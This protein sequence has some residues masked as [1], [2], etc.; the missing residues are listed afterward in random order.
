MEYTK[1]GIRKEDDV[2]LKRMGHITDTEHEEGLTDKAVENRDAIAQIK[3]KMVLGQLTRE[4]AKREAKPIIDEM[5][6]RIIEIGKEY[7]VKPKLLS[8]ISLMR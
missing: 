3:T 8:F 7:G 1:K 6:E 5:N 4:E 2:V